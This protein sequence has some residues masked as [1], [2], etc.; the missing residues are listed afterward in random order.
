MKRIKL[1]YVIIIKSFTATLKRSY[2]FSG[3]FSQAVKRASELCYSDEYVYSV[4]VA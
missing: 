3:S 4:T 2:V 1:D